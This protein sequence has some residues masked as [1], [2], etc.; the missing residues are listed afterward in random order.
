MKNCLNQQ[1]MSASLNI[2]GHALAG[3]ICSQNVRKGVTPF[4][5]FAMSPSLN[6][7]P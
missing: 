6:L 1:F 7:K 2:A 4:K 3:W 5:Q